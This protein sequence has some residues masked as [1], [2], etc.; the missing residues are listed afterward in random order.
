MQQTER[1]CIVMYHPTSVTRLWYT[2]HYKLTLSV[3]KHYNWNEDNGTTYSVM[4]ILPLT[5][6]FSEF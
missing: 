6:D 5:W 2:I 4:L 3:F 1:P